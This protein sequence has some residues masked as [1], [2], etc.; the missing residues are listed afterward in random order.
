MSD[1]CEHSAVYRYE[2]FYLVNAI[3]SSLCALCCL[4]VIYSFIRFK[5]SVSEEYRIVFFLQIT[6][7]IY[8]I[9]NLFFPKC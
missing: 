3:F 6:D 1:L 9:S 5:S 4:V 2:T 8:S 7:L